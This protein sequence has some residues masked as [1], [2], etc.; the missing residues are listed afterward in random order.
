MKAT[1]TSRVASLALML[2]LAAKSITALS[3]TARTALTPA[4]SLPTS[5]SYQACYVDSVQSRAL[6]YASYTDSTNMTAGNCIKFCSAKGYPLAGT[7]NHVSNSPLYCLIADL[8]VPEYSRECWCGITLNAAAA[9]ASECSYPCTGNSNEVC[10][11]S[12]RLTVYNSASISPK[13]NPGVNGYESLGCF[14]DAVSARALTN[15][16]QGPGGSQNNTVAGCTAT[17]GAKG[18]AYAGVE[19][20]GGTY[21]Q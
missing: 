4:T 13:V 7:G 14:T 11:G 8:N 9:P 6:K 17:C 12:S 1:V 18:Y 5:W 16:V 10:G 20:A 19:Y 2:L 15:I 21:F 3:L